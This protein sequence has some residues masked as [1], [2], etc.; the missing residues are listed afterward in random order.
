MRCIG[1]GRAA[2][3]TLCS[4][5][6]TPA[7]PVLYNKVNSVLLES[8]EKVAEQCMQDAAIEAVNDNNGCNE[9][10]VALDGTWQKRGHSSLHGVVTATSVDTGKVLDVECLSKYCM[11]CKRRG[12]CE[13]NCEVNYAGSSGGMEADGAVRIFERSVRV[14]E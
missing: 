6:N 10:A 8:L 9:I 3:K 4:V 1:K 7:P 12:K 5:L 11:S 14:G 13:D 2:G